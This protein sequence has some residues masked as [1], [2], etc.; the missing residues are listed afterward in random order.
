[1][2]KEAKFLNLLLK[3]FT[4][5]VNFLKLVNNEILF[6]QEPLPKTAN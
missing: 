4:I 5:Y 3:Y 6:W 1:M 2:S